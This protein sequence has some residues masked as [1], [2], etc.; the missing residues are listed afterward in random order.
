MKDWSAGQ[1]LKFEDERTRPAAEL[2]ARVPVAA[3]REVVDIGCGPGNSTELLVARYPAARVSGFDTSPAMLEAARKRLPGHD[4][5]QASASE[6]LPGPE[7]DVV[8]ANAVFQWLPDHPA[9]IARLFEAL[10]S[11]A[12]IAVQMPDNIA[13]PSHVL[14]RQTAEDGP[15]AAALASVRQRHPLPDPGFYYD[16]LG[17]HA[18]DIDIWHTAY[19]HVMDDAA[20]IV[21]WVKATGLRPFVDPL[22]DELR[23]GFLEAYRARIERAYPARVDGK[24]L[25]RF[26]RLFIVARRA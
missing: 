3:P 16:L 11:G 9:V 20:A 22:D 6:W 8:F 26:P 21:E 23:A 1:Y 19:N 7:T 13:E 17:P 12:A 24:R 4:F 18:A 25:L 14:M 2:L 10:P 5:V 15:W